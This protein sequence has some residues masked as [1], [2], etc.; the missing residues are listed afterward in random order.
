MRDSIKGGEGRF[1]WSYEKS[2]DLR[3]L[4]ERIEWS[5]WD[6]LS[7]HEKECYQDFLLRMQDG[8]YV[9]YINVPNGVNVLWPKLPEDMYGVM[10]TK[11]LIIGSRS[12]PSP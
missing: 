6:S 4:H 3:Q 10:R 2:A 11:T 5:G 8:D 7:K 1:G 9:V 12:I